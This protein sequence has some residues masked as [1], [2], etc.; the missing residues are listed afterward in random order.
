SAAQARVDE[1]DRELEAARAAEGEL[2]ASVARLEGEVAAERERADRAAGGAG[3]AAE[4]LQSRVEMLERELASAQGRVAELEKEAKALR[5]SAVDP[6]AATEAERLRGEV[7][8]LRMKLAAGG[9]KISDA[10]VKLRRERLKR[11]RELMR[12][13]SDKLRR[14][15]DAVRQ[16]FEQSEQVLAKRA[17]LAGAYRE[18]VDLREKTTK[19]E[20]RSSAY[21]AG[22][23]LMLAIV[24]L[25]GASWFV[26]GQ[27]M[28]GRHAAVV[29]LQA[30]GGSREPTADE[31]VGWQSYHETLLNEPSFLGTVADRMKRRGIASLSSPGQLRAALD[32]GLT[33][34]SPQAGTLRLELVGEGEARTLR[35][36]DTFS[37]AIASVSNANRTRRG[38]GL[39]TVL[40]SEPRL[41]DGAL[42]MKQVYTAAGVFGGCLF[43]F[44]VLVGGLWQRMYRS[45]AEFERSHSVE[46][47]IDEMGWVDEPER[48]AA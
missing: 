36:L 14:A 46:A 7:A 32:Q 33:H 18:F 29:A 1:L 40:A 17:E 19:R 8:Q 15:A 41:L 42:D 31:L 9:A 23:A 16:R 25:A 10:G 22:S 37:T 24:M 45:K 38:D 27:V 13:E 5:A 34:D 44:F 21:L 47:V 43:V 12:G 3:E 30:S 48:N 20:V 2:T 39:S 35:V 26:A 6:A 28:P 4:A 11:A